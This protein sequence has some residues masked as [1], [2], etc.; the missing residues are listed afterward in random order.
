MSD[1]PEKP[2]TRKEQYL[3]TI[4][5]YGQ[6][7]PERPLTREEQYLDFIAMNGGAGGGGEGVSYI[8]GHGLKQ[9]GRNVSVNMYSDGGVDKTLPV[10]AA[11]VENAVGNI[12][13]L[14]KS[15]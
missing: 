9:S 4:A 13:V 2:L 11:T 5:G 10:S 3:A 6:G 12:E 14:L 15:I 1:L 7:Y 8:F